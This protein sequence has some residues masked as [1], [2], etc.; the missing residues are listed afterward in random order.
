MAS[1]TAESFP[2]RIR[3]NI[4]VCYQDLTDRYQRLPQSLDNLVALI[5]K[6]ESHQDT[7]YWDVTMM[8]STLLHRYTSF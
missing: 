4:A 5:R 7:K 1:I 3:P 6:V 2:T 8:V